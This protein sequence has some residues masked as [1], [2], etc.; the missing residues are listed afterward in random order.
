MAT[1]AMGYLAAAD[2]T[3]WRTRPRPRACGDWSGPT[4]LPPRRGP[5]SCPRSPRQGY[6]ADADYSARAWLMHKTG[7]TRGAAVAHTAGR[8][9]TARIR[10]SS[11][12]WPPGSCRS[13]WAGDLPVDRPAAREIPGGLR[14]A[15]G[16]GRRGRP[17]PAGPVGAVRGDVRAGPV[18]PPDEDPDRTS[19]TGRCG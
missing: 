3:G 4:R 13:P 15:A 7:I 17:G 6:S 10:G 8:G 9:G 16:H 11:Q 2:A 19:T 18:R 1:A 5:R 12:R 14:R